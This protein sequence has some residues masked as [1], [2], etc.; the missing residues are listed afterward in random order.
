MQNELKKILIKKRKNMKKTNNF[1]DVD[2][3]RICGEYH[4]Q[5]GHKSVI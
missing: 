5:I 1:N 3:N 4:W 2:W